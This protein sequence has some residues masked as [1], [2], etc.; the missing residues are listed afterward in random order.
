VSARNINHIIIIV[1]IVY[2]FTTG[3]LHW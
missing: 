1:I 2:V 3:R